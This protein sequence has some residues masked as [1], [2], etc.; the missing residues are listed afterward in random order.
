MASWFSKPATNDVPLGGTDAE[1]ATGNAV[2][3][4]EPTALAVIEES[5]HNIDSTGEGP[6]T[7]ELSDDNSRSLALLSQAKNAIAEASS[8]DELKTIRDKAEAARKYAQAAGLGLEIQNQAAE[9]K[10]RAERKAGAFLSKLKLHGG[11]RREETASDRLT[12]DEI[13]IT[14]D[15]SSR[16]QLTAA[17]PEKVFNKYVEDTQNEQGEVTTAGLI[18]LAREHASKRKKPSAAAEPTT[19]ENCNVV[20][21]IGQLVD[22]RK[23]ACVYVDA[24]WPVGNE[25]SVAD[26]AGLDN[27]RIA[28][29]Q[30]PIPELVEEHAHLHMWATDESLFTAK[31]VMEGWGFEFKGTLVCLSTLGRPGNY[32][33]E[34]HEYLLLGVRGNLPLMERGMNSWMRAMREP[35]GRTPDRI[36]R[37]VERVSPGP[38]LEL[39][40]QKPV[41]GWTIYSTMPQAIEQ[42]VQSEK[43]V[44]EGCE[45]AE[46][47]SS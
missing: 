33:V 8:L 24:P 43:V 29:L 3:C 11:D 36:R 47:T 5:V 2:L 22:G 19:V 13:G 41:S 25:P 15:Q 1:H 27:F 35:D 34:A 45:D 28:L 6:P 39:F 12:L 46:T 26:A 37:L 9:I 16:W 42:E 31:Q 7:T 38:Y 21:S 4:E 20:N 18:K 30:Q 40:G 23:F 32:W 44:V 10:L 17:V 14:K